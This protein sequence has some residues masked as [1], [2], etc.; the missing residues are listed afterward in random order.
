MARRRH[1]ASEVGPAGRSPRP[2]VVTLR[3]HPEREARGGSWEEPPMPEARAGSQEEH[4]KE[5]WLCRPRRA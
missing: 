1:P 2:G 5:Q 3:S 4:P